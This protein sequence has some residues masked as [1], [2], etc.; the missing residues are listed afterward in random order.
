MSRRELDPKNSTGS[1]GV[2]PEE[3]LVLT[4][5]AAAYGGPVLEI[6]SCCGF[7]TKFILDGLGPDDMLLAVDPKHQASWEDP[8][9][10]RLH[11]TS[12]QIESSYGPGTFRWAFI[13]GSHVAPWPAHDLALVR[14]L[15]V[16]FAAFHDSMWKGW[17]DVRAA[18]DASGL[19]YCELNTPCGLAIVR[20]A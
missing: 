5:L 16:L 4:A 15:G 2:L 11:G 13:D 12:E 17:P 18:L 19:P 8:R 14:R 9:C 7:S 3:G 6:G 20:F 1:G 10:R